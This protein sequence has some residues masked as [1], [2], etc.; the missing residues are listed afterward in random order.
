MIAV[1]VFLLGNSQSY[2]YADILNVRSD[3]KVQFHILASGVYLLTKLAC[4]AIIKIFLLTKNCFC[5]VISNHIFYKV[6][7]TLH[8]FCHCAYC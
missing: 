5:Y 1:A 4:K 3:L 7:L 2:D 6:M 8:G